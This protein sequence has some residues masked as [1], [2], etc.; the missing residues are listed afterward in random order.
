MNGDPGTSTGGAPSST[1]A[2]INVTPASTV[3]TTPPSSNDW[4]SGLNEDLRGYVQNKG[5][6][7]PGAVVDSYRNLEK[8]RGV[9]QERLLTLP[10]KEDAP[11]W[12]AIYERLGKPKV[13]DEYSFELPEAA[14]S[15][16]FEK[17][18][19]ETFHANGLSKKAAENIM[20]QYGEYFNNQIA[21]TNESDK[22]RLESQIASLKK[23]WGAAYEQ[24]YGVANQAAKVFG[25][26]N[27]TLDSLKAVMG[28]ANTIKFLHTIGS[29]LGQGTFVSGD[30]SG[31]FNR[32]MTPA[33][34]KDKLATLM[35][36]NDF[37]TKLLNG[38]SETLEK[39]T[40]LHMYMAGSKK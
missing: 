30:N 6:K 15:P 24:N 21:S 33:E 14:K 3:N 23:E 20:K 38:H 7:D 34:A 5:F 2:P 27:P 39:Y 17:W 25:V 26:D 19:K 13:A 37:T 40:D 11:E 4:I 12:N 31:G 32:A 10:D 22:A 16:E 35:K 36:D 8:L 1:A 18:A 9:P 28:E 29:K